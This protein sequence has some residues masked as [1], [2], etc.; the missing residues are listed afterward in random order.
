MSR[1]LHTEVKGWKPPSQPSQKNTQRTDDNSDEDGNNTWS[2][3][4]MRDCRKP[5][6]L[7][8]SSSQTTDKR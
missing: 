8:I 6:R 7:Y 5:A 1:D 4:L 3:C 2:S